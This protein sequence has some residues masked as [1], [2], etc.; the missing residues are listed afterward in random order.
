VRAILRA[1]AGALLMAL[2]AGC[3]TT[4]ITY[5]NAEPLV[6]FMAHDYFDL[7]E[8]QSEQFRLRLARFHD[9]HRSVELPAYVSLLETT[10]LKARSPVSREDLIWAAE[11]LRSRYRALLAK[12]AEDAAPILVTLTPLQITELEKR[13]AKANAKYAEEFVSGDGAHRARFKRMLKRFIDWTGDL[14]DL[15]EARIERFVKA[16][17]RLG[18]LRLEDRRRWHSAAVTLIREQR[19]AQALA[20]GLG[21]VFTHPEAHRTPEYAEA[22]ARWE[23]ELAD[24][25]LD[26]D[27]TLS[28]EQRAQVVQHMERYAEDFRVLSRSVKGSAAGS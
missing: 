6:R 16:H 9:W 4:R 12:A 3:S 8:R 28:R 24:L 26:I 7:D 15:Q 19:N 22:L 10:A 27:R 13:L 1:A 25:V 11:A 17:A 5:N 20:L 14:T 21:Q 18:A 23:T 2:L